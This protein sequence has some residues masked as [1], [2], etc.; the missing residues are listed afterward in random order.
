[1]DKRKENVV[2]SDGS[3]CHVDTSWIQ[4]STTNPREDPEKCSASGLAPGN[5]I[6]NPSVAM[7]QEIQLVVQRSAT[8]FAT[9]LLLAYCYAKPLLHHQSFDPAQPRPRCTSH[10]RS[11]DGLT[12]TGVES[13]QLGLACMLIIGALRFLPLALDASRRPMKWHGLLAGPVLMVSIGLVVHGL[14]VLGLPTTPLVRDCCALL[15]NALVVFVA[16]YTSQRA[17]GVSPSPKA[18]MTPSFLTIAACQALTVV[19]AMVMP[20]FDGTLAKAALGV[21]LIA[22]WGRVILPQLHQRCQEFQCS[23]TETTTVEILATHHTRRVALELQLLCASIA[24]TLVLLQMLQLLPPQDHA[25]IPTSPASATAVVLL[26]RVLMVH[27]LVDLY[28]VLLDPRLEKA[29]S[30][31]RWRQTTDMVWTDSPDIIAISRKSLSGETTTLLNPAFQRAMQ[32]GETTDTN[33]SLL[34]SVAGCG[35]A[36]GAHN[37]NRMTAC[38]RVDSDSPDQLTSFSNAMEYL[39]ANEKRPSMTQSLSK[40]TSS[41]LIELVG[42]A[43]NCEYKDTFIMHKLSNGS[44]QI[45]FEAKVSRVSDS[46][47]V[48]V[49]RDVDERYRRFDEEKQRVMQT[50]EREKDAEA[51]WFTR[52]E[53]KNGLLAAIG[54]CESLRETSY[55]AIENAIRGEHGVANSKLSI[56]KQDITRSITEL[57]TTLHEILETALSQ[58]MKR[59]V[60][61]DSYQ[62][63]KERVDVVKLLRVTNGQPSSRL[64]S[65]ERFPVVTT[66]EQLPAFHF[67][68]HLLKCIHRHAVSNAC[69]YGKKGAVVATAVLFDPPSG[70]LTITVQNLPGERHDEILKL[71]HSASE[72]VFSDG[73]TL[74]SGDESNRGINR[75]RGVPRDGGAIMRKCAKCLGG[76]CD[77]EFRSDRTVFTLRCPA[78]PFD[79]ALK[80]QTSFDVARFRLPENIWGIGIDDSK[81]Q[82]KLLERIFKMAGVN[83]DRITVLG[84]DADEIQGFTDYVIGFIEHHPDDFFFLIVDENLDVD[85]AAGH[86][87][88]SGSLCVQAIRRL[89]MPEDERR[90]LALVRSANDSSHDHAVYNSRAHGCL[91]KKPLKQDGL[92]DLLAP[93]WEKRY[94]RHTLGDDIDTNGSVCS[95]S[96]IAESDTLVNISDLMDTINHIDALIANADAL[97]EKW[98]QIWEK[99]FTLKGDILSIEDTRVSSSAVA[100]ITEMR[101]PS[102]PESF[103]EKWQVL[104]TVITSI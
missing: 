2:H 94:S 80:S 74:H 78:V 49:A 46:T 61:H 28:D 15:E 39:S 67:D 16:S 41:S 58:A 93:L 14:I 60:I 27:L 21:P 69:K 73:K 35:D 56:V 83:K 82:R 98:E 57:D 51:N 13:S 102:L 52:H 68:P 89:L 22:L 42:R 88:V 59:D 12:S 96:S 100:T 25:R 18:K 86:S 65:K 43:W 81:I 90:V 33:A 29:R 70:T 37:N 40:E 92:M 53:V 11:A 63:I 19:L 26:A 66:P 64:N 72:I 48:L 97:E 71:G 91:P 62:P 77:I 38:F 4:S 10:L 7:D 104:R 1:M 8:A 44:A 50:M 54:L 9:V 95:R 87:T 20:S 32:D 36:K 103:L 3:V 101:G 76:E 85:E 17:H 47:L 99:L 31:E 34:F 24:P 5:N 55:E 79:L 75:M 6:P 30:T 84:K 45:Q 23:S